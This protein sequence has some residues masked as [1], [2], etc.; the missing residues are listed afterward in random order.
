MEILDRMSNLIVMNIFGSTLQALAVEDL[1][2]ENN[3]LKSEVERGCQ[4][5]QR[6]SEPV[7]AG[8]DEVRRRFAINDCSMYLL[9]MIVNVVILPSTINASNDDAMMHCINV[10]TIKMIGHK[11]FES[12]LV[13]IFTSSMLHDWPGCI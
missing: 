11:R 13:L 10:I 7:G 3:E 1:K 5:P 8:V 9:T 6:K 2:R 12:S 4:V